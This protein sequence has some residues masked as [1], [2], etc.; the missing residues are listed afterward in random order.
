[1]VLALGYSPA[2]TIRSSA[3]CAGAGRWWLRNPHIW[4]YEAVA[5]L[6]AVYINSRR[7]FDSRFTTRFA[8]AFQRYFGQDLDTSGSNAFRL[9]YCYVIAK[10]PVLGGMLSNWHRLY[11]FAR[12]MSTA[13]F[14]AFLYALVSLQFQL[15]AVAGKNMMNV[16]RVLIAL[17]VVALICLVR[18]YYL[19]VAYFS[20]FTVRAFVFL[21]AESSTAIAAKGTVA[22]P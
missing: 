4:P 1:V 18:Y 19:Y 6:L 9:T 13:F 12:N 11:S 20:K 17:W 22:V 2:E 21:T 5:G 16:S 7:A 10:S 15:S 14:L 3:S 8:T